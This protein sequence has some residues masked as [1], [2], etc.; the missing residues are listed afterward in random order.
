MEKTTPALEGMLD[1]ISAVA[2]SFCYYFLLGPVCMYVPVADG[3]LLHASQSCEVALQSQVNP[4]H[5]S[6]HVIGLLSTRD[7]IILGF[8]CSMCPSSVCFL[9]HQTAFVTCQCL[10]LGLFIIGTNL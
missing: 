10:I 9:V 5:G 7:G 2:V 1:C 8:Y 4:S 3:L 6:L